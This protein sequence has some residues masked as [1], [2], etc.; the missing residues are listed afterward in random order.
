MAH[1]VLHLRSEQKPLEHRSCLTPSTA[2]ALI[3]EGYEVQVEHSPKDPSRKRIFEDSEFET[4]GAKLVDDGSWPT[5]PKSTLIIGLKELPEEPAFPLVHEHVQFAH[6]YKNQGGWQEVLA[7]FPRGGGTLYD[8]EFLEVNKRRVAAFGFHAGFAGS[9]IAAKTWVW[10]LEHGDK[11]LPGMDTFTN[12]R[13]YYE[14]EDQ[15]LEQLRGDIA[16]GEKIAGRMPRVLVIGALG[17][18]GRGA[19]DL[20]KKLGVPDENIL[21]WDLPETSAKSGP[22]QEIVESDIFVNCIYLSEKIPPFINHEALDSP[23][24]KLTVVCDVS[25]DTTNPNNPIPIYDINT[26][27]T[28]PTV[29]VK[30]SSGPKLSVISIDHL[31]S[32]L[33]RESSEAFSND[34]LP[35]LKQLKDRKT[36]DV[37]RQAEQLF[38]SKVALLP[39][40]M[41]QLEVQNGV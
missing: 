10:Q 8:L 28:D 6:C 20:F 21:K 11:P 38:Q 13:G 19:V 40:E 41:R 25:C 17:R 37:W 9:A 16:K 1:T 18:C 22:Y 14:N 39:A 3:A 30:L 27:F 12:G 29:P 26:I 34:L 35:Y 36:A 4:V 24:R 2:K 33:P 32:L 7:R 23:S 5:V 15:M 31:P